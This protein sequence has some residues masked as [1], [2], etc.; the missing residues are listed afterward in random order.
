M[1]QS[2]WPDTQSLF[3]AVRCSFLLF[4][5]T[6]P[7]ESDDWIPVKGHVISDQTWSLSFYLGFH[8]DHKSYCS[9]CLS[10]FKFLRSY[11]FL[12]A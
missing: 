1:R 3:Y 6:F 12:V 11:L 4:S 8:V 9:G 5:N 7:A 10:I 2:F